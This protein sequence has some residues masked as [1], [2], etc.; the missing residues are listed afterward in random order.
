M[1]DF[2]KTFIKNRNEHDTGFT[3]DFVIRLNY[4]NHHN[5]SDSPS[6]MVRGATFS[7]T[8]FVKSDAAI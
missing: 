8:I 2:V 4:L 7:E 3:E 6:S 1:S 5:A